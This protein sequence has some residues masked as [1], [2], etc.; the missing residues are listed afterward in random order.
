MHELGIA[1]E[2]M[3]IAAEA[4][5]AAGACHI[6]A[7]HLTVGD[8]TSMVDDSIRLCFSILSENT[9]ASGAELVISRIPAGL[10]CCHCDQRFQLSGRDWLCPRCGGPA[11][12]AEGAS[13]FS[14]ESVEVE[15]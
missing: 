14:V 15:Y 8:L 13:Q 12:L 10:A 3:R 2:I 6:T 1:G 7:I 11:V 9:L 4:A 5:Q